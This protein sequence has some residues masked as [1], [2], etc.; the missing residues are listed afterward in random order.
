L[1]FPDEYEFLE[2]DDGKHQRPEAK[3]KE[4]PEQ[5]P[6][7]CPSCDFLKPARV[8]KCAACGFVPQFVAPV[9][10]EDG[11]LK[12]LQRKTRKEYSLKEKQ[13][14]LAQ[15]NQHASEKGFKAGKNGCYGWSLH[16]YKEKFGSDVPS[17]L[18]WGK[19]EPIQEPIGPWLY[20]SGAAE[21]QGNIQPGEFLQQVKGI[22]GKEIVPGRTNHIYPDNFE[23]IGFLFAAGKVLWSRAD[24]EKQT[25]QWQE[26]APQLDYFV[27]PEFEPW[28][29]CFAA[30]ILG[31]MVGQGLEYRTRPMVVV[32]EI[33]EKAID[34]YQKTAKK[35]EK[36]G[37]VVRVQGQDITRKWYGVNITKLG[38][39]VLKANKKDETIAASEPVP[40]PA[41]PKLKCMSCGGIYHSLTKAFDPDATPN[42]G[43][44]ELLPKYKAYAW[45]Q[46]SADWTGES[47]ICPGCSEPHLDPHTGLLRPGAV[48]EP[49]TAEA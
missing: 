31:G 14:F 17:R 4:K 41:G 48:V 15:L 13:S 26:I 11:E 3:Q 40:D 43:M 18:D 9:E 8:H 25:A 27:L 2:L 1:G 42:G 49:E 21:Y 23:H 38:A 36:K 20:A 24:V 5:L 32:P 16:Q 22:F 7:K 45:D 10:V 44:F 28:A 39:E 37:L 29:D 33:S 46:W 12:K 34:Q 47:L 19:R 35:L 30:E 6:Q